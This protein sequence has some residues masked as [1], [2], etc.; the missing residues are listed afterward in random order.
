MFSNLK[1]FEVDDD[2]VKTKKMQKVIEHI[3]R[4]RSLFRRLE[5]DDTSESGE[6]NSESG[7]IS[8]ESGTDA[9][10]E[11]SEQSSET[12]PDTTSSPEQSSETNPDTTSSPEQ[13]S[14]T[15]PDTTSSPQQSSG[16]ATEPESGSSP[17]ESSSSSS[18]SSDPLAEPTIPEDIKYP[19]KPTFTPVFVKYTRNRHA[20]VHI[21][22]YRF[23]K[24]E[25]KDSKYLIKFVLLL[26]F[27]NMAP[28]E[29]TQFSIK[30]NF[31]TSR[32]ELQESPQSEDATV[33]CLKHSQF[34][35]D[36]YAI[37]AYYICSSEATHE[38]SNV[39]SYN[40][41]NFTDSQGNP[42]SY[43]SSLQSIKAAKNLNEETQLL[44][45]FVYFEN[46]VFSKGTNSTYNSLI[47]RGNLKGDK[48]NEVAQ[49]KKLIMT[50]FE[51]KE[52]IVNVQNYTINALNSSCDVINN[53]PDNFAIECYPESFHINGSQQFL[54][55]G[56]T[57]VPE[58]DNITKN[59]EIYLNTSESSD[60][61][62]YYAKPQ[63][64]EGNRQA[65]ANILGYNGYNTRQNPNPK[66]PLRPI[67]VEFTLF[68][69]FTQITPFSIIT[70]TL[71]M[72]YY[73][74]VYALRG[75]QTNQEE[76]NTTATCIRSGDNSTKTVAYKCSAEA[77]KVPNQTES[78][79]NFEFFDKEGEPV[80]LDVG[81]INFSKDALE[82]AKNLTEQTA[83][84]S[85]IVYFDDAK[86]MK[87]ENENDTSSFLVKGYL[88]GDKKKKVAEQD[89]LIIT[90]WDV[91]NG[92]RFGYNT[93]CEV[94][95]HDPDDFSIK[96]SPENNVTGKYQY[97][98]NGTTLDNKVGIYLNTSSVSD[99]FSLLKYGKATK[100]SN[101]VW[102]KTSSGL[103]G[104]AIAGI[105]I[106][107]AVT[108]ILITILLMF[109][110]KSKKTQENNSTIVGLK[111]VDYY[112]E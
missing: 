60:S 69:K 70:F 9:E 41:Y 72:T 99:S 42:V 46:A 107:C 7:E 45:E 104:G 6:D 93:T 88:E 51:E 50:F 86:F 91:I 58:S 13:S 64:K 111:S 84:Y 16:N 102:R 12:N 15:N 68:I 8:E 108:L 3:E 101:V 1:T 21:L 35:F 82:G 24:I 83:T 74:V 32:R 76:E 100:N 81:D 85:D 20:F 103:S 23:F 95:D 31:K 59:I 49:Q 34:S 14:E 52:E 96:C 79:N 54:V 92:Q 17:S 2:K 71:K 61:F 40:N 77:T 98:T 33:L 4:I 25:Q 67:V 57:I 43:S 56:T 90:F 112:N 89:N 18:G 36:S 66:N 80:M 63:E 37:D 62:S 19:E 109:L 22:R 38:I 110:R 47:I 65:G 75:L 27:I 78:L 94:I 53:N 106:A 5:E 48:R 73:N 39:E 30:I 11:A 55:N 87:S 10:S 28:L 97:L 29:K 44:R 105:V 26:R